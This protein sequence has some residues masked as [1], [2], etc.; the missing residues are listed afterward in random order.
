MTRLEV[1]KPEQPGEMSSTTTFD[2]EE[3]HAERAEFHLDNGADNLRFSHLSEPLV[4]IVGPKSEEQVFQINE[5]S[6]GRFSLT[7]PGNGA[8]P[9]EITPEPFYLRDPNQVHGLVRVFDSELV[10]V[11]TSTQGMRVQGRPDDV[12]RFPR[13]GIGPQPRAHLIN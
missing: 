5:E 12:T 7:T 2:T 13:D 4:I 8:S 6:A 9:T 1:R 3:R 11:C 10:V